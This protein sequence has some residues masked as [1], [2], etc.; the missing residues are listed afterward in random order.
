VPSLKFLIKRFQDLLQRSSCI[1]FET[2]LER[3][4]IPAPLGAYVGTTEA[5][6]VIRVKK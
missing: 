5:G 4:H 3:E 1:T 2:S 6:R